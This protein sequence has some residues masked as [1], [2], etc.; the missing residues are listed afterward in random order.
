LG[1]LGAAAFPADDGE[2][3]R[4]GNG[5]IGRFA[6]PRGGLRPPRLF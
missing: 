1:S 3:E 5:G 2:R 6:R 4:R